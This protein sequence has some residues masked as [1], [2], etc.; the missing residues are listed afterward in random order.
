METRTSILKPV[1]SQ[2]LTATDTEKKLKSVTD[3]L[4]PELCTGM[5]K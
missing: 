2:W 5:I 4:K 3:I 1:Y